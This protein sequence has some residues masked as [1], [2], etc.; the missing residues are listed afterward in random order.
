[1][2]KTNWSDGLRS[3]AAAASRASTGATSKNRPKTV[4]SARKAEAIPALEDMNSRR[5]TPSRCA[6]RRAVARRRRSSEL[7]RDD[8]ENGAG[9]LG[10]IRQRLAVEHLARIHR[11]HRPLVHVA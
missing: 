5:L 7:H 2:S 9:V 11:P 10:K 8:R 6:L 4:F 1:M 3:S